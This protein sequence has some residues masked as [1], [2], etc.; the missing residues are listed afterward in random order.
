[1]RFH[2]ELKPN[3]NKNNLCVPGRLKTSLLASLTQE[4]GPTLLQG[5]KQKL[6][7]RISG[8][9]LHVHALGT[10]PGSV[11]VRGRLMLLGNYHRNRG[12]NGL[13]RDSGTTP[14]TLFHSIYTIHQLQCTS[15]SGGCDAE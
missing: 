9:T 4:Q 2:T 11:D 8:D 13:W 7:S 1:M 12:P 5:N 10:S 3:N 14:L 6:Q 15:C